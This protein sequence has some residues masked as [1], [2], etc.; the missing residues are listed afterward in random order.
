MKIPF[1]YFSFAVA[2]TLVNLLSQEMVTNID[3]L[4]SSIVPAM[5]FGT[6]TGL[7]TK[8]YLDKYFIFKYK[9][10]N[11][12]HN[13]KVFFLYTSTGIA[14]TAIFWGCEM[15]F[16]VIFKTKEMRYFGAVLGLSIGYLIKYQLDKKYV[17]IGKT[18]S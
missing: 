13:S 7:V 10:E 2:S 11:I 1:L 18:I 5:L 3:A 16:D 12:G 14:T 6:F 4:S 15:G 8:F 17:F 9:T